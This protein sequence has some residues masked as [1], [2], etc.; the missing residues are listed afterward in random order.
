[1]SRLG[2]SRAAKQEM[3]FNTGFSC[4]MTSK[5]H[6]LEWLTIDIDGYLQG[7]FPFYNVTSS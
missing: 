1:M 6:R 2:V 4:V 3:L 7:Q 5:N